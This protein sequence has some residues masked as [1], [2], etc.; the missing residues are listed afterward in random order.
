MSVQIN[1]KGQTNARGMIR[2]GNIN[3]T[4]AWSF[5]ASDGNKLLGGKDGKTN[6]FPGDIQTLCS[7]CHTIAD[8][9]LRRGETI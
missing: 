1:K 3:S 9:E 5:S 4:A 2:V 6:C 8:W 7:R